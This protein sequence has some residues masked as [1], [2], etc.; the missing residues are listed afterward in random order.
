[1]NIR[2]LGNRVLLRRIEE[3]SVTPGGIYIPDAAKKKSVR[4]EVVEVGP[5]KVND[6]GVFIETTV[7]PGDKV[8]ITKWAGSEIN[9]KGDTLLFVEEQDILGVEQQKN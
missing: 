7:K 2:V 4:A 1:M 6:A 8:L 9:Y 5:G 3:D